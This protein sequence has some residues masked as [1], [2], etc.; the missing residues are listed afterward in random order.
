MTG[1]PVFLAV[2]IRGAAATAAAPAANCKKSR[3]L[4]VEDIG[5]VLFYNSISSPL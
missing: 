5:L 3:R 4:I 1:E 2:K